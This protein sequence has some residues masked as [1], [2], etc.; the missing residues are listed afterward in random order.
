[1]STL[2]SETERSRRQDSN[3]RPAVYKTA[4]LPLSYTGIS[5]SVSF[6][7]VSTVYGSRPR[8]SVKP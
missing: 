8:P 6:R 5:R 4:A 2:D 3:P 1:M 7:D